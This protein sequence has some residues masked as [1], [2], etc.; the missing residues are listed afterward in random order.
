MF[1][2]VATLLYAYSAVALGASLDLSKVNGSIDVAQGQR[3]G[4]VSTV[5]GSIT[6]GTAAEVAAVETVN[7]SVRFDASAKVGPVEGVAPVRHSLP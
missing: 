7:G 1:R 3:A 6:V 5:N 4:D 2:Y